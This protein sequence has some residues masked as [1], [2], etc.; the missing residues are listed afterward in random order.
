MIL[1][2]DP[3][4]GWTL[5]QYPDPQPYSLDDSM[6]TQPSQTCRTLEQNN[7]ETTIKKNRAGHLS[8]QW[9]Q[10]FSRFGK[11]S[12]PFND[13]RQWISLTCT[14]SPGII[15]DLIGIQPLKTLS[16]TE[17][18]PWRSG[19]HKNCL[20]SCPEGYLEEHGYHGGS[21]GSSR[22]QRH[23]S[24]KSP[25]GKAKSKPPV[26]DGSYHPFLVKYRRCLLSDDVF[27]DGLQ[28]TFDGLYTP[29]LVN[30]VNRMVYHWVCHHK[31]V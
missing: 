24:K 30:M 31:S 17:D 15:T 22:A 29:C 5:Y 3:W 10:G 18:I 25:E 27:L 28:S 2:L 20:R 11:D 4:M 6:F 23:L 26:L 14:A 12:M 1:E 9:N 13:Q 16:T 7:H 8:I 19:V 21:W